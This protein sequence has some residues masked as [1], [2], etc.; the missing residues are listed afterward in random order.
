MES[1]A[2]PGSDPHYKECT[3]VTEIQLVNDCPHTHT[4]TLCVR[5]NY[6]FS[7]VNRHKTLLA[8]IYMCLEVYYVL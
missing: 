3:H 8:I 2:D 4:Q 7:D 1:Y 6:L 5:M